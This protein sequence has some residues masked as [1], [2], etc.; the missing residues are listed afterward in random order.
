MSTGKAGTPKACAITT[1]AVLCPT[2]GNSS[3]SSKVR[4]TT[5]PC[6]AMSILPRPTSAL[7]FWGARPSWRISVSTRASVILAILAGVPASA[8]SAGV[9]SL[10]F[11]SVHCA[12]STTA[13]RSVKASVWSNGTGG[14]G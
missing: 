9:I 5:P 8:K 4:G 6:L 12:E 10:T 2:P 7:D 3:S 1:E 14:S 11:L 13:T